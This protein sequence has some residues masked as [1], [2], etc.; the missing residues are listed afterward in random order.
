VK[1][2]QA[3]LALIALCLAFIAASLASDGLPVLITIAAGCRIGNR[4]ELHS[5]IM[6]AICFILL[7]LN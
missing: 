1:P 2:Y 5:K 6:L 4:C 7:N 3:G